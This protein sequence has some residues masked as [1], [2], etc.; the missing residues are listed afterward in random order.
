MYFQG[1]P[2]KRFLF[3]VYYSCRS[4]LSRSLAD[5]PHFDL[6]KSNSDGGYIHYTHAHISTHD[7][8]LYTFT[9]ICFQKASLEVTVFLMTSGSGNF[10]STSR[11]L[12]PSLHTFRAFKLRVQNN[13]VFFHSVCHSLLICRSQC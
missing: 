9:S 11:V 13:K 4:M 12:S 7:C 8:E 2:W 6:K 1:F 5:N 3:R 10:A